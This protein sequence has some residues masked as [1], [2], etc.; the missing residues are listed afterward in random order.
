MDVNA[1]GLFLFEGLFMFFGRE[2]LKFQRMLL[3][4]GKAGAPHTYCL[5]ASA[6]PNGDGWRALY[7]LDHKRVTSPVVAVTACSRS[8]LL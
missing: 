1:R 8:L 6:L 4:N 7:L 3:P 5:R 2:E